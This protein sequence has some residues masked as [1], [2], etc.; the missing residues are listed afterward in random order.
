MR[1]MDTTIPKV[2]TGAATVT[3]YGVSLVSF[4]LAVIA[5][6][7]GDHS[8]Q[9]VGVI[10]AGAVG[11]GA[12]AVTSAGRFIQARENIRLASFLPPGAEVAAPVVEDEL[13]T[14]LT[15]LLANHQVNLEQRITAALAAMRGSPPIVSP[16]QSEVAGLKRIIMDNY[17]VPA[18]SGG[19]LMNSPT[20]G[21][22]EEPGDPL[23]GLPDVVTSHPDDAE[24]GGDPMTRGD[25]VPVVPVGD[26]PV[27]TL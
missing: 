20:Q 24:H 4:V 18:E 22:L 26:P 11:L 13:R 23:D 27:L 5:F 2:P 21:G 3:G 1:R 12:L 6:L 7:T 25:V 19:T 15:D 16:V 9:T 14:F 17:T 8:E 10:V